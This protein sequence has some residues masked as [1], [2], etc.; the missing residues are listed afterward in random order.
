MAALG[1]VQ[2]CAASN[3][4]DIVIYGVD[5]N[6]DFM[7]YVALSYLAGETVESEIVV[8]VELITADNIGDFD[9]SDWQ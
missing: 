3:R 8:P 5:G 4:S 9:I 1:C 7:S 6:P 2:A